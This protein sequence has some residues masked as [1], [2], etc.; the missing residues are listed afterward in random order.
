[1]KVLKIV[2][3]CVAMALFSGL[4]AENTSPASQ[5]YRKELVKRLDKSQYNNRNDTEALH[6]AFNILHEEEYTHCPNTFW[7]KILGQRNPECEV[8]KE[9]IVKVLSEPI[10]SI[11]AKY[12]KSREQFY[13]ARNER[14]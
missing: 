12:K 4:Y 9:Y 6:K 5:A 7:S 1:M 10:P 14:T 3:A 11:I 8:V 13:A 2:S